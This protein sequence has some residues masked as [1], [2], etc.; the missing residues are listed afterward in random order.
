VKRTALK[1]KSAKRIAEDKA[2]G[3]IRKAVFERDQRCMAPIDWGRCEGVWDAHH[4]V[5][6]ARDRTLAH[7]ME[8]LRTLC[9]SHH[10]YVHDN[11]TEATF[12]GLLRSAHAS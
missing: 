12:A 10:Q 1:P 2:F 3:P 7:D 4:V 5:S 6:R 9:R 8:N 11:P